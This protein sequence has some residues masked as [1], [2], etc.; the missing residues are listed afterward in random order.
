LRW[1]D[2][3]PDQARAEI[4]EFIELFYNRQRMHQTLGY[5]SPAQFE[6]NAA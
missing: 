3:E 1:S 6:R 2:L 5:L 4:F